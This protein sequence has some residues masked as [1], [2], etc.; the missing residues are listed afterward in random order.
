LYYRVKGKTVAL[1]TIFDNRQH[2]DKLPDKLVL[3]QIIFAGYAVI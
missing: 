2:P 1:I 3:S